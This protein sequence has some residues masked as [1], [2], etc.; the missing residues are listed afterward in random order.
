MLFDNLLSEGEVV[1][2]IVVMPNGRAQ[3]D[4]RAKGN[5]FASAPAFAAFEQD[6]LRDV[7]PTIESRFSVQTVASIRALAGPPVHGPGS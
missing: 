6:L 5:V 4:D 2:M 7:I 3:K 1:P